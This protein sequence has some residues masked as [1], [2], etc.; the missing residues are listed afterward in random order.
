MGEN[1]RVDLA[2]RR[3]G[4]LE[5]VAQGADGSPRAGVAIGVTDVST[6]ID[7]RVWVS[8][9][10]VGASDG[11]F[12]TDA[13]GRLTLTGLPEGTFRLGAEGTQTQTAVLPDAS[14]SATITIP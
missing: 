10:L 4:D 7:V 5:I 9:G 8:G 3:R 12:R 2:I 11:S 6:G 1:L 14:A 13:S